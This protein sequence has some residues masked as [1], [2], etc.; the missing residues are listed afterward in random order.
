MKWVYKFRLSFCR[1]L[2]A[3]VEMD[4]KL[5]KGFACKQGKRID[6]ERMENK[7]YQFDFKDLKF[8]A[9]R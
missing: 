1:L 8:T 9:V 4:F 5:S 7:T 6:S 2:F 3:M